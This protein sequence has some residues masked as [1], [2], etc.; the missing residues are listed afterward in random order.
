MWKKLQN[1]KLR[2]FVT[3]KQVVKVIKQQADWQPHMN[4]S[5]IF[6]RWRQCAPP[7]HTWFSEPNRV[8]IPNGISISSAAFAQLMARSRYAL[9]RAAPFLP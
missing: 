3:K 4:G 7:T 8:Q 6:A 5:M 1:K 9:Q 2:A